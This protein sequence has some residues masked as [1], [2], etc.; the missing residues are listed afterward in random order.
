MAAHMHPPP[1]IFGL[2]FGLALLAA[3]LAGHAMAAG[4]SRNWIHM[5]AF[6]FMLAGAVYVIFDMEYPRL[7]LIQVDAFDQVL[8][9]LRQSMR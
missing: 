1:V 8:I 7:G 4:R 2:L 5:I 3:L 6:A 9:D